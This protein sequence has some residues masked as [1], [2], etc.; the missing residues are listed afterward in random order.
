MRDC[1]LWQ[2]D[3]VPYQDAWAWQKA[4]VATRLADPSLP[5]ALLLLEHPPVYTLGQGANEA[6]VRFTP[7]ATDPPV[8][9]I[10]R[11][12]EVTY[13]CP[14]QLVGYPILNL[15]R[16]R[17]DLHWYLRQ[18]EQVIIDTLADLGIQGDRL[19]PMTGVWVEGRKVAAIGIK[20]S[21]WITMHGFALNICPDL[22]G[23]E[24]IVPCGITDY[25]VGSLSQSSPGITRSEVEPV[26]LAQFSSHFGCHLIPQ[27]QSSWP[28]I[29][30]GVPPH[31]S[32]CL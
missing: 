20:V 21:R 17:T 31:P 2:A 32:G 28:E 26:L 6:W 4:L 8:I 24:R 12:G 27:P 25:P 15:R 22:S 23:F 9:R 29:G 1:W 11:G 10:E 5:D 14:G 18:L 7:T 19:P 30:A 3:R 16:Y 13:H